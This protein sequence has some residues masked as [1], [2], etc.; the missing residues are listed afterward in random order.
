MSKIP[1][2]IPIYYQSERRKCGKRKCTTCNSGEGHGPYWYAYWVEQ[3]MKKVAYIGKQLPESTKMTQAQ[4]TVEDVLLTFQE[5]M[6]YLKV[7]RST[8]YRLMWS[9]QLSGRKVGSSWRFW[10]SD[11]KACL[12]AESYAAPPSLAKEIEK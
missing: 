8:L 7:S 4:T 12:V 5:A 6:D 3:G 2:G 1:S 9:G 11:V 10:T